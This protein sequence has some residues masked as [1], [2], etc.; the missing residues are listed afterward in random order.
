MTSQG[1]SSN[2][3]DVKVRIAKNRSNMRREEGGKFRDK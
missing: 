2:S 1:A 3:A